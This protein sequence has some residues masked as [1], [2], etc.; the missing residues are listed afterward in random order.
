MKRAV[1]VGNSWKK[2]FFLLEEC[3]SRIECAALQEQIKS[4]S[5][6][7]VPAIKLWGNLSCILGECEQCACFVSFCDKKCWRSSHAYQYADWHCE[8]CNKSFE[9][10]W[11][12]PLS[13]QTSF[14]SNNNFTIHPA[15]TT[16]DTKLKS[17]VKPEVLFKVRTNL[18]CLLLQTIKNF[19]IG[20][21]DL[22]LAHVACSGVWGGEHGFSFHVFHRWEKQSSAVFKK[23]KENTAKILNF[24]LGLGFIAF[25]V[26]VTPYE[27][28][29]KLHVS[30]KSIGTRKIFA[31]SHTRSQKVFKWGGLQF[32]G[33]L[34]V[35]AGGLT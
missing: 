21:L 16:Q 33:G 34:C 5:G 35:C 4:L 14:Q 6:L 20:I 18:L 25:P 15:R 3:P 1:W 9:R 13:L 29:R 26:K 19:S 7:L 24:N 31:I 12:A 30:R 32:C 10:K 22:Q 2:C 27:K 23:P 8:L 17:C 11:S 28:S